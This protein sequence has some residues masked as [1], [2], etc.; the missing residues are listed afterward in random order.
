MDYEVEMLV[1]NKLPKSFKKRQESYELFK[2]LSEKEK[3]ELFKAIGEKKIFLP[4][5]VFGIFQG[6][7]AVVCLYFLGKIA[8]MGYIY[9]FKIFNNI[10]FHDVFYIAA[11]F[12]LISSLFLGCFE[13]R[14]TNLENLKKY[15]E[16][17]FKRNDTQNA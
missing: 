11:G 1:H 5:P 10:F 14:K 4:S 3:K 6:L 9:D 7:L 2:A 8:Q 13:R 16:Q 17:N 15:I 12:G